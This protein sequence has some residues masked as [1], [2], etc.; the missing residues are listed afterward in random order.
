MQAEYAVQDIS[1]YLTSA[2][3]AEEPLNVK[4]KVLIRCPEMTG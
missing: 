3:F 4:N 2:E 1:K